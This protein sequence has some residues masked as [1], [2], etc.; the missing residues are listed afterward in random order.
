MPDSLVW[1]DWPHSSFKEQ[2]QHIKVP[3]LCSQVTGRGPP[4][5]QGRRRQAQTQARPSGREVAAIRA[6][7][8]RRTPPERL[9]GADPDVVATDSSLGHGAALLR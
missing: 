5:V 7:V 2:V 6:D 8:Q 3:V 9:L 1:E 4:T